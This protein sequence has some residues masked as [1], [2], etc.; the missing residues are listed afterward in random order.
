MDR[1][2]I[3][4]IFGEVS[5]PYVFNRVK[6]DTTMK[7]VNS[8]VTVR[9]TL[10]EE[11][12]GL[13]KSESF[14]TEML[15][16]EQFVD[17][18]QY[19]VD[20]SYDQ[21]TQERKL[22]QFSIS[23]YKWTSERLGYIPDWVLDDRVLYIKDILE[24]MLKEEEGVMT[25]SEILLALLL[26]NTEMPRNKM[27]EEQLSKGVWGNTETGRDELIRAEGYYLKGLTDKYVDSLSLYERIAERGYRDVD[28]L[29]RYLESN[30]FKKYVVGDVEKV[31]EAIRRYLWQYKNG[32]DWIDYA[33]RFYNTI[34]KVDIEG[35]EYERVNPNQ[36]MIRDRDSYYSIQ[37]TFSD[38]IVVN[39]RKGERLDVVYNDQY[40][41]ASYGKIIRSFKEYQH[42]A[43][44]F[45]HIIGVLLKHIP[46][47]I[48]NKRKDLL[49]KRN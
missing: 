31:Q 10:L 1:E 19:L 6:V 7:F 26:K 38:K 45:V 27:F 15:L 48:P 40:F 13:S 35:I 33:E 22:H 37:F 24:K 12:L 28:I 34:R 18:Y 29:D 44:R 30:E 36:V 20:V 41:T 16:G 9:G 5:I 43:I 23:L 25:D 11:D 17:F 8:M 42:L 4:R 14:V 2:D 21:T 32:E 46:E 47:G 39:M 49:N 3:Y